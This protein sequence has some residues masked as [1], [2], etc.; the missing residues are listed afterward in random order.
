MALGFVLLLLQ[1]ASS[2]VVRDTC[3][4][5]DEK[6]AKART[7][8]TDCIGVSVSIAATHVVV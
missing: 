7:A 4:L 6:P 1:A 5:T 8:K 2:A 3:I